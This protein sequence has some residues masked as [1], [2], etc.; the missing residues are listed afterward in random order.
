MAAG[1]LKYLRGP[2]SRNRFLAD[3]FTEKKYLYIYVLIYR[4]YVEGNRHEWDFLT[5]Y[6]DVMSTKVYL[7]ASDEY[8][9]EI[10]MSG[11]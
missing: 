1:P 7:I 9:Q 10:K 6:F 5:L 3:S 4:K 2:P 11:K 8:Y